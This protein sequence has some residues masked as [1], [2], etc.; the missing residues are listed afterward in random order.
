VFASPKARRRKSKGG[1]NTSTD[2]SRI[3]VTLDDDSE[4]D[5]AEPNNSTGTLVEHDEFDDQ[6]AP[7]PTLPAIRPITGPG[8]EIRTPLQGR[9]G[10]HISMSSHS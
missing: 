3:E 4:E 6:P 9:V 2:A 8:L 10:E 1:A 5:G 7:L